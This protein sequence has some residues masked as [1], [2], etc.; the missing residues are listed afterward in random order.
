[1]TQEEKKI[2]IA[3]A[4]GWRRHFGDGLIAAK[5]AYV[6]ISPD[7]R[8]KDGIWKADDEMQFLAVG[9]PD[10]FNDLNTMHEAV[11]MLTEQQQYEM[12]KHLGVLGVR[13]GLLATAAQRAEAF[14]KTLDLW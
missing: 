13:W 6:W 11:K 4:R 8:R 9:I 1:M 3:E 2:K 7:G 14:G 10:H 12:V 5:D